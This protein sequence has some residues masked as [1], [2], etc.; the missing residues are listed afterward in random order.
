MAKH[1][2]NLN[3]A[4]Q[5]PVLDVLKSAQEKRQMQLPEQQNRLTDIFSQLSAKQMQIV[6]DDRNRQFMRNQQAQ[7]QLD[8]AIK[9]QT[10]YINADS[11]P[12]NEIKA[13]FSE[14]VKTTGEI[15]QEQKLLALQAR[16]LNAI[17]YTETEQAQSLLKQYELA[18]NNLMQGQNL[19]ASQGTEL[20][21][22]ITNF[23]NAV[24]TQ[25]NAQFSFVNTNFTLKELEQTMAS[26]ESLNQFA[27]QIGVPTGLIENVYNAKKLADLQLVSKRASIAKDRK[28]T[29]T[30]NLAQFSGDRIREL[31]R[32]KPNQKEYKLGQFVY[33]Q[34]ELLKDLETKD[35]RTAET[36]TVLNQINQPINALA[37]LLPQLQTVSARASREPYL[38][39]DA[40]Q[41]V[42]SLNAVANNVIKI[43]DEISQNPKPDE[44]STAT[45]NF[46]AAEANRQMNY[47]KAVLKKDVKELGF[48]E[49]AQNAYAN[50]L[51]TG[52][53]TPGVPDYVVQ[54][55]VEVQ[56]ESD[57]AAQFPQT[58]IDTGR[59]I[60]KLIVDEVASLYPETR[61]FMNADGKID[62]DK[63]SEFIAS[64]VAI[65]GA[66][67]LPAE[68]I[69]YRVM[70]K[71]ANP[72]D[73]IGIVE[74]KLLTAQTNFTAIQ[75]VND[76]AK[77]L[78][79]SNPEWASMFKT[80]M[81]DVTGSRLNPKMF[82]NRNGTNTV[83]DVMDWALRLQYGQN[84]KMVDSRVTDL[85]FAAMGDMQRNSTWQNELNSGSALYQMLLQNAF[86]KNASIKMQTE[87]VNSVRHY[88]LEE[89]K[90]RAFDDYIMKVGD[91]QADAN[92]RVNSAFPFNQ[93]L[94]Q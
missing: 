83:Q 15:L 22:A 84:T 76:V 8:K 46:Y 43:A 79:E 62:N 87:I 31:I 7:E 6:E 18:K 61:S 49:K 42:G 73:P 90:K 4:N 58:Q 29:R 85:L 11:D 12:F 51:L 41:A 70:N 3:F 32:M 63:M 54:S 71:K 55:A 86:G 65:Q 20:A 34:S 19:R 17:N 47:A 56:F 45:L 88:P 13:L 77:A 23:G 81:L 26:A 64:T 52:L 39:P 75:A 30:D 92:A 91:P 10:E 28:L 25:D 16:K 72:N 82:E 27:L 69:M 67:R 57:F 40:Y 1:N 44:N 94:G 36:R 50:F 93:I 33:P 38:T 2:T 78:E 59:E 80:W 68:Q 9:L 74:Q 48:N 14:D 35:Q 24:K 60:Y 66:K 37:T 53:N 21:S 89:N 5:N